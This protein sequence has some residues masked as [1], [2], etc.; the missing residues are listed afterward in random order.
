[1]GDFVSLG[2]FA[3]KDDED[4]EGFPIGKF[5]YAGL[6]AVILLFTLFA[7]ILLPAMNVELGGAS[8]RRAYLDLEAD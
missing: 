6:A 5:L 8:E 2:P 7:A 3:K 1:M 4:E